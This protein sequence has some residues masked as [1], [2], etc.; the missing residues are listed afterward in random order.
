VGSAVIAVG[1]LGTAAFGLL[2]AFKAFW[3]GVSNAGWGPVRASLKPFDT[4]LRD[5][6]VDWMATI[7]ANWING[8]PKDDQ[9]M[10]AKSL[11]RLGL[12][13]TNAPALAVPGRVDPVRLTAVMTA[14]DSGQPL[15]PPDVAL[16][17][18]FDASIDAALDAGFE[19]GDQRYR[20][21][22]RLCAGAIAVVLS[23]ATVLLSPGLASGPFDGIPMAILVGLVAVP[24][25]PIAKDLAS[26]LNT[27]ANAFKAAKG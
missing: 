10:A 5:A 25:A 17:A 11:V 19:L 14:I 16:L 26:A 4:A 7:H 21:V 18:R 22:A 13:P 1:A 8:V 20:S 12:S 27:A 6:N 9:K 15:G 2:D 23:V 3:G 24:V